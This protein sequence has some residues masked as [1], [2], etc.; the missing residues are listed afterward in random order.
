MGR[1]VGVGLAMGILCHG[2]CH[3]WLGSSSLCTCEVYRV[4]MYGLPMNYNPFFP[5]A[6]QQPAPAPDVPQAR[7]SAAELAGARW[8]STD[9][10][11]AYCERY[12][13]VL[14]ADWDGARFG[15]WFTYTAGLPAD[16]VVLK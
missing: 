16:A 6:P 3:V 7:L 13:A 4:A 2:D 5:H 1:C 11:R 9:G 14:Q 8:L 10:T 15:S 12:G